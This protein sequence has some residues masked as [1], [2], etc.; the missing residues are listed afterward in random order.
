VDEYHYIFNRPPRETV[1]ARFPAGETPSES[2]RAAGG[3]AG[4][5]ARA[6]CGRERQ[7]SSAEH[8]DAERGRAFTSLVHLVR[9]LYE[10]VRRRGGEATLQH[11]RDS[12]KATPH[13]KR[14]P[15]SPFPRAEGR[16]SDYQQVSRAQA[17]LVGIVDD[18]R[19]PV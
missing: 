18:P 10:N 8:E 12:P 11:A 19:S 5:T 13:G 16:N 1:A 3:I 17:R 9:F 7:R 14:R 2:A 15:E 6:T 4:T